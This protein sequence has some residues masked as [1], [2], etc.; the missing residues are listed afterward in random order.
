MSGDAVPAEQPR[1]YRSRVV[2]TAAIALAMTAPGQTAAVSAFVDPL[3]DGLDISRSAISTAYLIGTLTGAATL[4]FIGRAIDRYGPKRV[5]VLVAFAFGAFLIGLSAVSG[6]VGLT[7]GFI[8]IRMLGQGALSLTATTTVALYIRH[9]RGLAQGIATA[10]GAAGISLAPIILERA[11]S[12]HGFR[13]AW[14]VEGLIVW[15][16][17]IPLALLVLPRRPPIPDRS[18]QDDL[19]PALTGDGPPV[20]WTRRQA[21]RTGIFWVIA[22]GVTT[23]A[24]LGTALTFHQISLL[25]ERGLTPSQAAATFVPLM[26]AGLA[27]TLLVGYL[28]D[29]VADRILIIGALSGLIAALVLAAYASPG[30]SAIGYGMALGIAMNSFH[31]IEAVAFPHCFGLSHLGAIRGIVHTFAVAGSAFGPLLLSLGHSW[32]D[33]YRPV[34]L[35]FIAIP[36]LAIGFAAFVKRPPPHPDQ[37]QR[38]PTADSERTTG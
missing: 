25:G 32:A 31:T 11:V 1:W 17:V 18:E 36:L 9:R 16:V 24:T 27:A 3:L 21:M 22:S 13:T 26:L 34:V 38:R 15:A 30:L 6:I 33:S 35:A 19:E 28:A 5:F 2:G 20:D 8:G 14:F 23:M 10:A 29:L 4:P 37:L 7:A 12:A